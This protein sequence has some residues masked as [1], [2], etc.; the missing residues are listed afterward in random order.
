MKRTSLWSA[1]LSGACLLSV[2]AG[3]AQAAGFQLLEYSVTG[4][5]RSYA[6]AGVVGDDYSALALFQSDDCFE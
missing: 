6:G 3:S 1:A 4:L 5:G 2:Y